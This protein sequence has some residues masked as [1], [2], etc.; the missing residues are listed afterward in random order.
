MYITPPRILENHSDSDA[1]VPLS[2]GSPGRAEEVAP[3]AAEAVAMPRQLARRGCR[4]QRTASLATPPRAVKAEPDENRLPS[5]EAKGPRQLARRGRQRQRVL[6]EHS[7]LQPPE[8]PE[9]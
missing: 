7:I 4:R 8:S 3:L 2:D 1:T 5:P 6:L 9:Y